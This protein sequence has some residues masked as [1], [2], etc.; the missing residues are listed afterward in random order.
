MLFSFKV[1]FCI[2]GHVLNSAEYD[3]FILHQGKCRILSIQQFAVCSDVQDIAAFGSA[4]LKYAII[5]IYEI[6]KLLCRA[7]IIKYVKRP[8]HW[9]GPIKTEQPINGKQ[10]IIKIITT[11]CLTIHKGTQVIQ[12][13][14]LGTRDA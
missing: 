10:Q 3:T 6:P 7:E 2:S 11:G 9:G 14:P 8:I 12:C 4:K 1:F 13:N 5:K